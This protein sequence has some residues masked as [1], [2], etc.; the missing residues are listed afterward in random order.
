MAD[1]GSFVER[2]HVSCG[3]E[4]V[5]EFHGS[6]DAVGL[7]FAIVAS[8]FNASMTQPLVRDALLGLTSH[9]ARPE[10]LDVIWVPGAF[11]IPCVLER[12]AAAGKHAALIA[13]GVILQ[14]ETPHAQS[15]SRTVT[16]ALSDIACRRAVPV[17]DGIVFAPTAQIAEARCLSGPR[18]RGTYAAEAAIEMAHVLRRLT[19]EQE[20]T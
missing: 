16:P 20:T 12:L 2:T 15:I 11:E 14:G 18:S 8:R 3:V 6:T 19:P 1:P 17:I 5:R 13:I 7:S 4:G 10:G 9:G